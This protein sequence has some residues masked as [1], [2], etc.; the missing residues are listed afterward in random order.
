MNGKQCINKAAATAVVAMIVAS[1]LGGMD[2]RLYNVVPMYIGHEAE[3]AANSVEMFERTGEGIAL[4]SLSLHPEGRPATDKVDR[5]IASY[6][7]FAKSLAGTRV[8][9][10][11]LVQ[12]ILGHW[13]R[14]D[15]DVEGWERTIDQNGKVVRFCPLDPGFGAY[16][17]YVFR[18]VA[19]ER[20]AFILIDDDVR[21]FSHGAECFCNS[22]V[23]LFNKRYGTGYT[24]DS[25]RAAVAE[26]SPDD[27]V[28]D[29]F[30]ALQREMMEE[31]VIGR[32]RRAIDS[33]DPAIPAGVCA[34]GEETFSILPMARGIAAM[35]QR[36]LIRCSTGLYCEGM[37]AASFPWN[38]ER[39]LGFAEAFRGEEVDLLDEADT[40]PQT[41]WSKSARSFMTHLTASC[42][43][44]MRGAK[45]WYV[46][47]IR[48][49]GIPVTRAYTDI[50]AEN[51]GFLDELARAIGKTTRVGLSVPCF[52]ERHDWHL[53]HNHGEG[54]VSEN[55]GDFA[56]P[57]FGVP[58]C[59]SRDFG[60]K[61]RVF[62]LTSSNEVARLS[63]RQ[64]QQLLSGRVF[65]FRDAA[66]E[67]TR[68]G[69]SGLIGARAE[70]K[71][72]LFTAEWDNVQGL[73]LPYTAASGCVLLESSAD[74][75]R[76][77]DFIYAPYAGSADVQTVAPSTIYYRNKLGGEVVV[78]AYHRN[79][80]FLQMFSEGR[81]RWFVNCLDKL[82]GNMDAIICGNDQYVLMA[83]ALR[84][85]G[86]RFVLAVNL[87][88]DP[89]RE[90]SLRIPPGETV[91][92]LCANGSWEKVVG[93]R[94]GAF[95]RLPIPIAFYEAV[96]VR[97]ESK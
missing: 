13:P 1:S 63:D 80:S 37:S 7:A 30:F 6:R 10:G 64:L 8:C 35:G 57:A 58:I 56:P 39:M 42:F 74:A 17:D 38:F 3:Q 55:I 89:I 14:A 94:D 60:D 87:S 84:S 54:F 19:N 21:A 11:I 69:Q 53:V 78:A 44:G 41:L 81:K 95:L 9:S 52:T 79:M 20:P 82:S 68:R 45:T 36:P 27:L 22:H 26:S 32:I 48:A 4:Y 5:Y 61:T 88:S 43:A 51:R 86:V 83:Q 59:T 65:I 75:E 2:Y 67:L 72:L 76:L 16:I 96:V 28:Y 34:A 23:R 18:S 70:M 31:H 92:R 47:G 25:L 15:R 90:L 77:C 40:C 93:T 73:R 62:A 85:D 33:V 49:T 46:N 24:S 97:V 71:P 12:S 91:E 29:G 50:L 66:I